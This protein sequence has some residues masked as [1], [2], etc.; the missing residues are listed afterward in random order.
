MHCRMPAVL[1]PPSPAGNNQKMSPY[2]QI[3]LCKIYRLPLIDI[4]E[5]YFR[6]TKREE[7]YSTQFHNNQGNSY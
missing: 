3:L 7:G 2:W 1:P 5:L 6:G 4:L